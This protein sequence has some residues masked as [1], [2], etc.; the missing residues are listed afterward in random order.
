VSR[1]FSLSTVKDNYYYNETQGPIT[2]QSK[3]VVNKA[4]PLPLPVK[5]MDEVLSWSTQVAVQLFTVNFFKID[6]QIG[7]LRPYFTSSGWDALNSALIGSGW[8]AGMVEKKLS[9]TAVVSGPPIVVRHGVLDGSYSWVINFPLLV[10]YE[11]ASEKRSEDRV[12]TV[13]VRR[14]NADYASGQAGMAIDS[15]VTKASGGN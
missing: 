9:S 1:F 7:E 3:N 13:T 14:I 8:A 5:S 4:I 12:F 6:S 10:T 2:V 11:G 15:F